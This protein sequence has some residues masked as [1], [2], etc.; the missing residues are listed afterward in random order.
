M[1]YC[2]NFVIIMELSFLRLAQCFPKYF[3]NFP[4]TSKKFGKSASFLN[5]FLGTIF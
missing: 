3:L 1:H 4:K 2:K 5:I